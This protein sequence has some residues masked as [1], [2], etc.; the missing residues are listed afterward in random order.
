[1]IRYIVFGVVLVIHIIVFGILFSS[2]SGEKKQEAP[3]VEQT[4][5]VVS[6]QAQGSTPSASDASEESQTAAMSAPKKSALEKDTS[7]PGF[8]QSPFSKSYF[9]SRNRALPA[10]IKKDVYN[11]NAA[12]VFD[13][14]THS[15]LWGHNESRSYAI[16]SL[17]KMMTALLLMEDLHDSSKNVTLQTQVKVTRAASKIGGRQVWLDPRESFCVEDLLKAMMIRS[18]ND[19]A[20][21]IGEFLAGGDISVFVQ[22]MNLRAK[23][24]N[25]NTLYYYNP[26]GLPTDSRKENSGSVSELAYLAERLWHYPELIK[27]TSTRIDMIRE[28]TKPFQLVSTNKL[29]QTC[30]GV[31]GLKTGMTNKAGYCI[32]V[33]C[34]REGRKIIVVVLGT[35][36][37]KGGGRMRDKIAKQLVDWAYMDTGSL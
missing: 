6:E 18:A 34:E 13:V 17:T 31:V 7:D 3:K 35:S 33:I 1:M 9:A 32:V 19:C 4:E 21:Q 5:D 15:L 16:A 25:C 37:Q 10:V 27:W 24:L 28:D 26:H 8:H 30:S 36:P 14:N 29:L 22:R 11:C 2:P 12:G 20:Y 23:Q